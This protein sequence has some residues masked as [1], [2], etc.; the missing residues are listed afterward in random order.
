[1]MVMEKPGITGITDEL[2]AAGFKE[3]PIDIGQASQNETIYLKTA[4]GELYAAW[5]VQQ[6]PYPAKWFIGSAPASLLDGLSGEDRLEAV[7]SFCLDRGDDT[8]VMAKL[9][10]LEGR[11]RPSSSEPGDHKSLPR[12]S[13]T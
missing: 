12:R 8:D 5:R 10:G 3:E 6:R 11:N 4:D 9:L 1:M 2:K 13:S 7:A